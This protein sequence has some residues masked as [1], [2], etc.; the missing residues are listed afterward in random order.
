M[1]VI[2]LTPDYYNKFSC[3]GGDCEDSCCRSRWNI[4][5][6][7][8]TYKKYEKLPPSSMKVYIDKYIRKN[9]NAKNDKQYAIIRPDEHG[10]CAL[11]DEQ[12][13]CMIHK[14]L[15]EGY[16]CETCASYPRHHSIAEGIVI[17]SLTLSCPEVARIVLSQEEP[18]EFELSEVE[19]KQNYSIRGK[20]NIDPN[21]NPLLTNFWDIL[22]ASITIMQ[23]R[24]K[25][26]EERLLILGMLM[27]NLDEARNEGRASEEEVL[28]SLDK[29]VSICGKEESLFDTL[30][31]KPEVHISILKGILVMRNTFGVV[32]QAFGSFMENFFRAISFNRANEAVEAIKKG[33]KEYFE[34]F[35]KEKGYMF[36][37]YIINCM[38]SSFYPFGEGKTCLDAF[39]MLAIRYALIKNILIGVA[40]RNKS[41]NE[42]IAINLIQSFSKCIDH[43]PSFIGKLLEELK[44]QGFNTLAYM[45]VLLH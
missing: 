39:C 27:K 13:L 12:G 29:Y 26:I 10:K 40:I 32:S 41:I 15:G 16:L 31:E 35:A 2:A 25:N 19:I 45:A 20:L 1:K 23:S 8:N 24:N 36:E 7:K 37:N 6:D 11:L 9:K 5:L 21:I 44:E 42:E 38:I 4:F 33:S 28:S 14:N 22:K 30:P 17:R 3:I 18:I 43:D 34:P